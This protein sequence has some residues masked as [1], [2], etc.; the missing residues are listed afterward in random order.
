MQQNAG[1]TKE[2]IAR[3]ELARKSLARPASSPKPAPIPPAKP[4]VIKKKEN[5]TS[6]DDKA[7]EKAILY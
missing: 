7:I 6:G 5:S 1:L 4:L 3:N 2:E